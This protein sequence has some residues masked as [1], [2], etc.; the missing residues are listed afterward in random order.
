MLQLDIQQI[1]SQ[2]LSF[3]LLLWVLRRFAWRPL[4]DVLDARRE[5]IEADLA[6]AAAQKADIERLTA[7]L[8]KQ[9]EVIDEESRA[10]IQQAVQEGRRVA[11]E[12][13]DDSRA[14]AQAI[15]EKSRETI[16]LELAKAKVTLRDE[17]ADMAI[18]T[19]ERLLKQKLTSDL[20][21]QFVSGVLDE[22]AATGR[23]SA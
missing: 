18:H 20:D 6:H 4:L 23:K 5:K 3:L 7:E 16:E 12:M 10:K 8:H 1:I 13:Q 11:M 21:R 2:A 9:L 19:V 15:L 17:M 14:Q 22:L